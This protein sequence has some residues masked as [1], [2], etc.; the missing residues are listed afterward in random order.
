MGSTPLSIFPRMLR[1]CSVGL[2]LVAI[3][4]Y[5]CGGDS[6]TKTAQAPQGYRDVEI[7][8]EACDDSGKPQ[9]LDSNGDGKP[10]I[11]QIFSGGKE[12]C[13]VT[14]LNHDGKPDQYTYFDGAGVV[15]RIEGGFQ[16]TGLVSSVEI[17][18]GG[19]LV[20]REFA[21]AGQD[22]LDTWDFFDPATGKRI[23]RE[24]DSNGDKRIDQW[25]T[26]NGDQVTIL[27]DR[28]EDGVADPEPMSE[29]ADAG[30]KAVV[31]TG[32]ALPP[33]PVVV[34]WPDKGNLV[35]G[36]SKKPKTKTVAKKATK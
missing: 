9:T 13:R 29:D 7:H 34:A 21:A 2:P 25:W 11:K 28:N 33:P 14:D 6:E 36:E 35:E 16:D 19:K 3:A 30:A 1:A 31:T 4:L 23:K 18:E 12:V 17:Y 5:A 32:A 8:H 20:R 26:W 10:E 22:R 27:V 24:R 15:R